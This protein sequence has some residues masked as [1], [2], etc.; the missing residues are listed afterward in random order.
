MRQKTYKKFF[1]WKYCKKIYRSIFNYT[2]SFQET[3]IVTSCSK[4]SN[5]KL[6][7]LPLGRPLPNGLGNLYIITLP[8]NG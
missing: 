3:Q 5:F 2:K 7:L 6:F 1:L 8:K 4:L